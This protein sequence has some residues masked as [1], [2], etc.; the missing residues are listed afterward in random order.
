M[1]VAL[2]LRV[3]FFLADPNPNLSSGLVAGHGEVARNIL[4]HGEWFVLNRAD[5]PPRRDGRPAEGLLDP[6][7][8]DYSVADRMPEF[9]PFA[10]EMPGAA[11]VLAAIWRVTGDYDYGY[12]QLLQIALDSLC[13]LL[14]FW[15]SLRLFDRPR[16]AL[17]AAAAYAVFPPAAALMRIAHLDSWAAIFTI[18]I[19][20]LFLRVRD[21]ARPVPW[22]VALGAAT[23]V[24]TYFRPTLLILPLFMALAMFLAG[25]RRQALLAG[26][27]PTLIAVVLL[28]PWTIRNLQDFDEFIPTRIGVGQNLWEGLGEIPNDF[29]AILDDDR[30]AAQVR[31]VRPELRYGTPQYDNYLR[32][33]AVEAIREHP[34]HWAK[35]LARRVAYSTVLLRN[36]NWI[37]DTESYEEYED[38]TGGAVA[39]YA[40]DRPF[41]AALAVLAQLFEPLLF[42]LA[43]LVVAL[44][45]RR[46]R[47]QH[48]L[49]LSIPVATMLPYIA[50]HIEA[51]YL[52]P[53][54]FAYLILV[55]LGA[56]LL[57]ER[58]RGTAASEPQ[59]LR[60]AR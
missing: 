15:C 40:R 29:G 42:L 5:R 52:I 26:L 10:L 49:L 45:W 34:D 11:M 4:V 21:A 8:L 41:Y 19:V 20:A 35:V 38:R 22:L 56:D 14:V 25:E 23:G 46:Y 1:A 27:V 16:A 2:A 58:R 60:A 50:L 51:R 54:E 53:H 3:A 33:K 24:G 9:E 6:S 43:M 28:V 39:D 7:D 55:A 37:E 12:L 31:R 47:R 18:A 44:T 59:D 13:V 57:L 48:L 17:L 36:Y 32:E 30:T